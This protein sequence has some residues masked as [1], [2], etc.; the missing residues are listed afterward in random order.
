MNNILKTILFIIV[1]NTTQIELSQ[2]EHDC[3]NLFDQGKYEDV[4]RSCKKN[5]STEQQRL[6]IVLSELFMEISYDRLN[7]L[8]YNGSTNYELVS[9]GK[10]FKGNEESFLKNHYKKL[11]VFALNSYPTAQ[12]LSAKIFYINDLSSRKRDVE[13][14]TVNK[15]KEHKLQM[16]ENYSDMLE[17]YLEAR[18]D[19]VEVLFL[20][21]KQGL[22]GE[23]RGFRPDEMNFSVINDKYYSYLL[24]SA[25]LNHPHAQEFIDGVERWKRHLE[26]EK[27]QADN[28]N[29]ESLYSIGLRFYYK[30]NDNLES[31][32]QAIKYFKKAAELDHINSLLMLRAIY[33]RDIID[34]T[35]YLETL[36]KLVSLNH[37][38]SMIVLGDYYLCKNEKE[39]AKMLYIK[40]KSMNSP[41][42]Q[43]ALDDL[44]IDGEPS[45]G[46]P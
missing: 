43:V 13:E 6:I 8:F 45:N 11:K 40:A 26:K 9:G 32:K 24:K 18:P 22:K 35:K 38:D 10:L 42:A 12:L 30:K 5:E 15:F 3:I 41:L 36:V 28:N 33:S 16:K 20:L 27:N 1:S 7:H 29:T 17:S 37:D 14:F 4:L 31:L 39:K 2:I 46:C 34:E 19:D 44:R 21:G 23:Y 25:E